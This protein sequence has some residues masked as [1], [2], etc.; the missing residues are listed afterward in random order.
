MKK[1]KKENKPVFISIL[2]LLTYLLGN[3]ILIGATAFHWLSGRKRKK[4][5]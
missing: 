2:I 5:N 1:L 3:I 4:D